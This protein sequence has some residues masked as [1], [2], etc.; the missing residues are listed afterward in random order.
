MFI[1]ILSLIVFIYLHSKG[2]TIES[3]YYIVICIFIVLGFQF[4]SFYILGEYILN[5]YEEVK[6][7][8]RYIISKKIE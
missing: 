8:P 2:Y 6:N 4:I 7:R 3:I 1:S 5:I